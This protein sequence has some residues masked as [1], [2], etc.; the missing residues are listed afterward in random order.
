M[1]ADSY[2]Q[3]YSLAGTGTA[4]AAGA[5]EQ[6]ASNFG[7]VLATASSSSQPAASAVWTVQPVPVLRVGPLPTQLVRYARVRRGWRHIRHQQG[8]PTA[9]V[10]PSKARRPFK[11]THPS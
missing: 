10:G 3:S 2:S 7:A 5:A 11:Y 9:A 6:P 1:M 4:R 8:S